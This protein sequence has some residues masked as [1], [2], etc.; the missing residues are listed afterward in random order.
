MSFSIYD[1]EL[2]SRAARVWVGCIDEF[3]ACRKIVATTH[4]Y[5]IHGYGAKQLNSLLSGNPHPEM[6]EISKT[7][8]RILLD[9]IENQDL[10]LPSNRNRLALQISQ[11]LSIVLSRQQELD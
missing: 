1:D 2:K 8:D 3:I 4:I 11:Q 7:I 5:Y 10:A 6:Q 9:L